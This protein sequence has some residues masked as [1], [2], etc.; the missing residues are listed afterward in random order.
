MTPIQSPIQSPVQERMVEPTVEPGLSDAKRRLL[1]QRLRGAAK[2]PGE[3]EHIPPRE[4]GAA[5]LIG[6]EQY[7]VWID[8][9][10]QPDLPTYNEPVTLRYRG[11]LNPSALEQAFNAFV[12]RHEAWRTSF[13]LEQGEV[14]QQIHAEIRTSLRPVDLTGL[15]E[16]GREAESLR[17]AHNQAI[18]PLPLE[19]APLFRATLV[20]MA[21]D[22]F[23]LHLLLHHLIF[24][25]FSLRRTF[26]PELAEL[27]RAFSEGGQPS[28]PDSTL[29][30]G[31]F[32]NWRRRQA[33][34]PAMQPH[35]AYWRRQLGGELPVLRLPADRARPAAISHRG[36][37][38]RFNI[39]RDLTAGLRALGQAS[40]ATLYMAL[41]TT[42]KA[43]LLRYSGQ[44]SSP[45]DVI[46]GSVA[47]GRRRPEL[48]GMMGYILDIFAVRTRPEL[49]QSFS[50]YL[51]Q[52]R[53]A[54]IE[55]LGASEVPFERVVQAL[56]LKRDLSHNPIFQTVFAFQPTADAAHSLWEI[57]TT[58]IS[59]GT[60]KFDLYVEADEKPAHTAVRIFYSTDLFEQATIARMAGHWLTLIEG[61]VRAPETPLAELPLLTPA[62]LHQ[63][64]VD[65][66]DQA[67]P[68][69]NQTMHGL[70]EVQATRTPDAPAVHFEGAR[71][72]YAELDREAGRLATA[73]QHAGAR[74]GALAAIF[75]DRSQF[76]VAGLLGILKTGAAYLPLDPGTPAARIALCLEDAVPTV[77]LT[78]RSRVA[79]LPPTS[80]RVV[81]LEDILAAPLPAE[82]FRP[83]VATTPDDLAYIIHTSGST[84]RPKGVELRHR[85]VVNFLLSMKLEPGFTARDI[86]VAVTTISFDIA[87]LELF[88]PLITGG[89]VVVAPRETALDPTLLA[90]LLARSRCTVLQ[91]TPAT[92]TG[93]VGSQWSGKPGLKALCGGEAL[94]R[95]LADRLLALGLE[96]WN[97]YGPTETTIWSTVRRVEA[98]AGPIPVGRPIANTTAYILDARQQP[99][100]IGIPGELY[101]G[102]AG[103]ARGYR[104]SPDL[105]NEKFVSPAIS[106]GERLYRTGD[107]A[108]FREDG[109]IECQG[110]SDHQ[111]KVR[112]Y[113][114]ELED[115]EVN[116]AAHPAVAAAAAKAWP[117]PDGGWRLCAY[118]VGAGGAPPDAAGM[119]QFL[120]GRVA[121][122]M[123]PTEI[124]PLAELPLT[125]NGKVDRK[126]LARPEPSTPQGLATSDLQGEELRLARIWAELLRVDNIAAT[127]NFFDLGGHSLMLLR[128]SR[129]I[130]KE[131][132][133]ELPLSQL[134]QTP[135]IAGLAQ[136]IRQLATSESDT[137]NSLVPLN[138]RGSKRP[139]FLVHSLMLYGRLPHALGD[140]QPFYGLQPLPFEDHHGQDYVEFMLA[141]HIRQ[142]KRVQPH[143]PYQIAGWCFAG[144]LAYEVARRLEAGGDRVSLLALLDSWC[145]YKGSAP[146]EAGVSGEP[147]RRG[148]R[149]RLRSLAFKVN[150]RGRQFVRLGAVERRG[151]MGRMLRDLWSKYTLPL[152]RSA[153][154]RLYRLILRFNLPMPDLLR[155]STVVTYDWL[156]TY[157]VKPF[158]GEINLIRP[159]DIAVPPD[160][161]P[162]CGWRPLTSGE[163]RSHFVPGDRSTMFLGNNLSLLADV[164][165]TLMSS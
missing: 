116:L 97:V 34:S 4:P 127:D 103:L 118:L 137:W 159:G 28:L 86:L 63:M 161:D 51:R 139:L 89:Q 88:L 41:L 75:L 123:I 162:C 3:S 44:E 140:D 9:T 100:P 107:Y 71:L 55:A 39:P 72:T 65:W 25:G 68:I 31:D 37:V 108:I 90:A 21:E 85:G 35:L 22:D 27:Y 164:L 95:S 121:E 115:V 38:F 19:Q 157:Q 152:E 136:V 93:L 102:G 58:E 12:A 32:A 47:D 56:E 87:V 144:W 84:G 1:A 26:L 125:A 148:L 18:Q 104:N 29:Q 69:P 7:S 98:G 131:F 113:R 135:T 50:A 117:D 143:G 2:L 53:Q 15:P 92:W 49:D 8:A 145:P 59:T 165:R 138:P 79:D 16:A 96:L 45:A 54:V 64:L 101:L 11:Q 111:V 24:D 5:T 163:I 130:Q 155:D 82:P 106:G 150:F 151:A 33:D 109:S 73:L 132:A 20:R 134:F 147:I 154:S 48:E 17:L 36:N 81:V 43:V 13:I 129:L 30:Y 105:T 94:K 158:G 66:N 60:A 91:A 119:R 77:I 156:R 10:L 61:A 6:P 42:F 114:I 126:L 146:L 62:E 23:R 40:G 153:K 52:V 120:R 141:D 160:A 128:L 80:A 112:G 70:F 83:E 110:R 67:T 99:V 149:T 57:G 74:A 142:I 14:V 46:V 133:L 76:L 122:Y 124:V 78:Q